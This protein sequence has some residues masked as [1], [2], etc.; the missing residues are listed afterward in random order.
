[1]HSIE[2]ANGYTL[3]GN[4]TSNFYQSKRGN[5]KIQLTFF[6]GILTFQESTHFIQD[7][8]KKLASDSKRKWKNFHFRA[9]FSSVLPSYLIEGSGIPS[10][11]KSSYCF[12]LLLLEPAG[13]YELFVWLNSL[14]GMKRS[15]FQSYKLKLKREVTQLF[16]ETNT[17]I[18]IRHLKDSS[19]CIW[20]SSA[21]NKH[22]RFHLLLIDSLF[23]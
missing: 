19:G 21:L 11:E 14:V 10:L 7:F 20:V 1:M 6:Q 13:Y 12:G 5:L 2:N 9:K 15:N 16:N 8:P 3:L 17:K 22:F 23:K 4:S 18:V